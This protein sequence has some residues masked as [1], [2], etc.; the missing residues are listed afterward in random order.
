MPVDD[1]QPACCLQA[2]DETIQD[3]ASDW[4]SVE[5]GMHAVN[6]LDAGQNPLRQR[7]CQEGIGP[8][9]VKM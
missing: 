9:A 5:T 2:A 3:G 6:T 7:G 1:G 4:E 8:A